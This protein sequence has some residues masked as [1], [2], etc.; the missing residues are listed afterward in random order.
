MT[1]K[2]RQIVDDLFVM[3]IDEDFNP[4]I[5]HCSM[6]DS[7]DEGFKQGLIFSVVTGIIGTIVVKTVKHYNKK[8]KESK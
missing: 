4:D 3:V 7:Y 1:T 2:R 6:L 8:K 5:V